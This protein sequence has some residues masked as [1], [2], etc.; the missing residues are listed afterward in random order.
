MQ[1]NI[2]R[3]KNWRSNFLFIDNIYVKKNVNAKKFLV[4]TDL[5]KVFKLIK[6]N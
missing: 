2:S 6:E 1:K 3:Q 4:K 5:I